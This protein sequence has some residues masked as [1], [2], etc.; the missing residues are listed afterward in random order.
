MLFSILLT[1]KIQIEQPI[2]WSLIAV[3]IIFFILV[4]CDNKKSNK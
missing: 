4:E 2:S 1:D 3:V